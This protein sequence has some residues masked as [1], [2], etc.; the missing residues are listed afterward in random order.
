MLRQVP[1]LPATWS[2]NPKLARRNFPFGQ[3]PTFRKP[4]R[5]EH[6]KSTL[7]P[8]VHLTLKKVE[9]NDNII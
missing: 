3:R 2:I 6:N 7:Q 4:L 5:T 1:L 8:L 9:L